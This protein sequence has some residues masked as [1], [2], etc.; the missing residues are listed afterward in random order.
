MLIL[1]AEGG[2]WWLS[3]VNTHYLKYVP[4]SINKII[5]VF[6]LPVSVHSTFLLLVSSGRSSTS[7]CQNSF[8]LP[9]PVPVSDHLIKWVKLSITHMS[10]QIRRMS[11]E[12]VKRPFLLCNYISFRVTEVNLW[13]THIMCV[14]HCNLDI[15]FFQLSQQK[16]LNVLM[17]IKSL[18]MSSLPSLYINSTCR[19]AP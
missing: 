7:G 17:E 15:M 11:E 4:S 3:L 12:S 19:M 6:K 10:G 16:C 2:K 18:D 13:F 5:Y 9:V 1:T 8:Q 14:A